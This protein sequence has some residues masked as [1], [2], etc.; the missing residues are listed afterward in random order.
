MLLPAVGPIAKRTS[1]LLCHEPIRG[2][3]LEPLVSCSCLRA[4]IV[5][6]SRPGWNHGLPGALVPGRNG[7]GLQAQWVADGQN[8]REPTPGGCS[9]LARPGR[10]LES[11]RPD[12][13]DQPGTLTANS[14]RIGPLPR[15][16]LMRARERPSRRARAAR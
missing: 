11:V 13:G 2:V 12:L 5:L 1:T 7:Q 14:C 16:W 6:L 15:I 3:R 4:T 9:Q 10:V 8:V